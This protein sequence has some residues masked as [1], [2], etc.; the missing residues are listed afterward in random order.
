MAARLSFTTF[1]LLIAQALSQPPCHPSPV[2]TLSCWFRLVR[3]ASSEQR[4][5]STS[6]TLAKLSM[7]RAHLERRCSTSSE[8]LGS[9]RKSEPRTNCWT[10]MDKWQLW[11]FKLLWIQSYTKTQ[12]TVEKTWMQAFCSTI[13][14][15][16]RTRKQRGGVAGISKLDLTAPES[17]TLFQRI[18]KQTA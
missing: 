7:A 18:P 2:G 16:P 6:A 12:K 17:A 8:P 5:P 10:N 14:E 13:L 15:H 3:M 4:S 9:L 1:Y 11:C